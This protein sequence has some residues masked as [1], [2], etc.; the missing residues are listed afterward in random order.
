MTTRLFSVMTLNLFQLTSSRRGWR[1]STI[2]W[3]TATYFNS[4]PHEEDD[5]KHEENRWWKLYFNSHP[6]EE[7]D[8]NLQYAEE[9]QHIST[10]ILT[11]RMTTDGYVRDG[12][13]DDFNSHP[14]EEDDR[15]VTLRD[16][17]KIIFQLTSSRR[18][19]HHR[20]CRRFWWSRHFNSHP[21]EEDDSISL[22]I[23]LPDNYFN[24]HPH[25]EDDHNRS[26]VFI[27][28]SYFNSHPHE[29]DDDGARNW[30][31]QYLKFQL[32]SSR[33]GWRCTGWEEVKHLYIST[34]ILTKR[35]T[36]TVLYS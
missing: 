35:M 9:Q 10:H 8:G 3:R 12:P 32:T 21:H 11:K 34:H 22:K 27:I 29:E 5:W 33:R 2:R 1:Q 14:H 16:C 30:H 24:S 25:E 20:R 26:S 31:W 15:V 36:I 17:R 13:L 6:H 19:W 28:I 4:H 23:L 18:G 7:D